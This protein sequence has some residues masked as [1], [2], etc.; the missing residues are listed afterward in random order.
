VLDATLGGPDID[1][2]R[3][4]TSR[5]RSLYF[6]HHGEARMPFLALFDAPDPGDCYRRTVS[7]VPQQ[8]L[9]LAN[10]ELSVGLGRTL[11]DRLWDEVAS[12]ATPDD[13]TAAFVVAAFE[14]VLCRPPTEPER[15]LS[16]AFLDRQAALLQDRKAELEPGARA[17][18]D[19]VQV[20]MNHND[21]LTV[22]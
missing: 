2:A 8:A 10:S 5:R 21:F 9:A 19:L 17:R 15:S 18:A 14:Q 1:Q 4:L 6:T 11:A 3:G 16:L 13:R 12:S 20:L 7:V 22:H